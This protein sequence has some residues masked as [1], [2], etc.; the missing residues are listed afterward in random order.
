MGKGKHLPGRHRKGGVPF[1]NT[2][3]RSHQAPPPLKPVEL[4]ASD[5]RYS[6]PVQITGKLPRSRKIAGAALLYALKELSPP[7]NHHLFPWR[8]PLPGDK[9]HWKTPE[10]Q[11][12]V[13]MLQAEENR[14]RIRSQFELIYGSVS[15]TVV[16]EEV[17]YLLNNPPVVLPSR[18][19][20]VRGD[21]FVRGPRHHPFPTPRQS[22]PQQSVQREMLRDTLVQMWGNQSIPLESQMQRVLLEAQDHRLRYVWQFALAVDYRLKVEGLSAIFHP[23]SFYYPGL[24]A[25]LLASRAPHLSDEL[26]RGFATTSPEDLKRAESDVLR[27]RLLVM[28]D[29]YE[30]PWTRDKP[31][32]VEMI[33]KA[34]ALPNIDLIQDWRS[35]LPKLASVS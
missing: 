29:P 33:W 19:S 16:Y 15:H 13:E 31:W 8:V 20:V 23:D 9:D 5:L 18:L 34:H 10:V 25:M 4:V 6:Q 11:R 21:A 1:Q 17:Q 22:V 35:S 2:L 26:L 14:D 27:H 30:F 24:T 28:R 32:L 7:E 12:F 3:P